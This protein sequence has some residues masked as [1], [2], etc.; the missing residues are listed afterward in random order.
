M[1]PA[2]LPKVDLTN[3]S[4]APWESPFAPGKRHESVPDLLQAARARAL[5]FVDAARA[6]YAGNLDE[7]A[8]ARTLGSMS[9]DSGLP[10]A[11]DEPPRRS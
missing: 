2:R 1:V 3:E 9:Y 5:T 4:H 7:A 11:Q 6:F 8:L 10:C